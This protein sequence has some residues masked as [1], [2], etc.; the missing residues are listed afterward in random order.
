ML[1]YNDVL[2]HLAGECKMKMI[3]VVITTFFL[4]GC[5]STQ[6]DYGRIYAPKAHSQPQIQYAVRDNPYSEELRAEMRKCDRRFP[7]TSRDSE[8]ARSGC[9]DFVLDV[10]QVSSRELQRTHRD[11]LK[12]YKMSSQLLNDDLRRDERAQKANAR[13]RKAIIRE[14][15]ERIKNAK[16]GWKLIEDI[17]NL[18]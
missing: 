7:G 15:R 17:F 3:F 9:K 11:T 14:E 12:E 18:D 2:T 6:Q 10:F 16:E 8:R 1:S 4:V 5:I 13:E